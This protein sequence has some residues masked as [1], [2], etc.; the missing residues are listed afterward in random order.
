MDFKN[1]ELMLSRVLSTRNKQGQRYTAFT[2]LGRQVSP[3]PGCS[4]S[5]G[6][7][8]GSQGSLSGH[9][10]WPVVVPLTAFLLL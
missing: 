7:R 2:S 9:A 4:K 8:P 5:S 6:S 3:G 10:E 1:A